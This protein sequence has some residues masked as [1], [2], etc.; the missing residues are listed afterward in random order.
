MK[1][2]IPKK[3]RMNTMNDD[4][5]TTLQFSE[6]GT[7]ISFVPV[8]PF[9]QQK[10]RKGPYRGYDRRRRH[11][12]PHERNTWY[13]T[14]TDR[15][16]RAKMAKVPLIHLLQDV[17]PKAMGRA[18]RSMLEAMPG[19]T[20]VNWVQRCVNAEPQELTRIA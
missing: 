15:E 4:I 2:E 17:V 16:L 13:R 7:R 18:E 14:R 3:S 20:R 19:T 9:E 1:W 5:T 11:R 6:T 8:H 12:K 10:T